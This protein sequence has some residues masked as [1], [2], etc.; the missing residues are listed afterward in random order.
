[1]SEQGTV[2]T[3]VPGNI[4]C[5]CKNH[6]PTRTLTISG[7]KSHEQSRFLHRIRVYHLPVCERCYWL[8]TVPRWTA[9]TMFLGGFLLQILFGA[10]GWHSPVNFFTIFLIGMVFWLLLD[11]NIVFKMPARVHNGE[12]EW[13]TPTQSQTKE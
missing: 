6:P 1:M 5:R 2:I 3:R 13:R 4:C 12:L 11:Q 8:L 10:I 9:T 7:S